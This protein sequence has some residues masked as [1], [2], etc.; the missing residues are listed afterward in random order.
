MQEGDEAAAEGAVWAHLLPAAKRPPMLPA[1]EQL[2]FVPD[3]HDA[4]NRLDACQQQVRRLLHG[5]AVAQY[6]SLYPP[7]PMSSRCVMKQTML[8][9]ACHA[10]QVAALRSTLLLLADCRTASGGRRPWGESSSSRL[11]ALPAE[12]NALDM[13]LGT[14]STAAA[15][16]SPA[17][18][19]GSAAAAAAPDTAAGSANPLLGNTSTAQ[20]LAL[21]PAGAAGVACSEAGAEV[22]AAA[23]P[24][25]AHAADE[26]PG[27]RL[28]AAAGAPCQQGTTTQEVAAFTALRRACRQCATLAKDLAAGQQVLCAAKRD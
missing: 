12:L 18:Q 10:M 8:K 27:H 28:Q 4:G 26:P 17:A 14:V 19:P 3:A 24:V 7:T 20:Q 22:E 5:S 6:T 1:L 9:A 2:L 25:P 16:A 15:A 23:G 13:R 21:T 11:R